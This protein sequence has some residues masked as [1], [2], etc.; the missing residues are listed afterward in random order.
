MVNKPVISHFHSFVMSENLPELKCNGQV[1]YIVLNAQN[2]R[3]SFLPWTWYC[4]LINMLNVPISLYCLLENIIDSFCKNRTNKQTMLNKTTTVLMHAKCSSTVIL[5]TQ[6][7]V[8]LSLT[9]VEVKRH[10]KVGTTLSNPFNSE[11]SL[12]FPSAQ[13]PSVMFNAIT[14]HSPSVTVKKKIHHEITF[15]FKMA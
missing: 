11:D 8:I 2:Q 5:H 9:N 13:L 6:R 4:L 15:A 3:G 14:I 7:N 12:Y 10:M 1:Q